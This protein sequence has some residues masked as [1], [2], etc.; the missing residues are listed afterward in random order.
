MKPRKTLAI[1]AGATL[2]LL[3]TA[4]ANAQDF[5]NKPITLVVPS[6][7]GGSHDLTARALATVAEKHLG[8]PLIVEVKPG[9]TGAVG[10]SIVAN[11][12]PDGY[13]LLFGGPDFNT[14]PPIMEKRDDF[15]PKG[16]KTVCRVNYTPMIL[17]IRAGAPFK[18][19]PELIEWA[20]A[21]PGELKVAGSR[22]T[23]GALFLKFVGKTTGITFRAIPF[24]GGGQT[25]MALLSNS[26]DVAPGVP[27]ALGPH[28]KAGKMVFSV[29]TAPERHKSYPNVPTAK[30]LGFDYEYVFWRS[31]LAPKDTPDAIVEKLAGL[32]K[33]MAEDPDFLKVV[34]AWGDGANYLGPKEFRAWWENEYRTQKELLDDI[35]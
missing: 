30:E 17:A 21:H 28:E 7:A 2:A 25:M 20:K 34:G 26:A 6:S 3:A 13:T 11:A 16:F 24:E 14:T 4:A 1:L 22:S 18:T 35:Q 12:K 23:S 8:Q 32:C 29:V 15:G 5:P 19:F 33:E 10:S 31:I 9:G 27:A